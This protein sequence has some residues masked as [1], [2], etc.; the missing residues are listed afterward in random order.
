MRRAVFSLLFCVFALVFAGCGSSA[1]S[2]DALLSKTF[3][4]N[5]SVK[6]GRVNAQIDAN[7]QG[8]SGLNG[9]RL[10]LNGPF[11][12]AGKDKL[13]RFDFTL[14]ISAG[15]QAFSAGGVST[16][17][18]GWLRVNGQAYAVPDSVFKRFADSYLAA[19]RKSK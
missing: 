8:V 18:H 3:G 6:S 15:G 19:A 10:R 7:V 11:E 9:L 14:G 1:G 4:S 5:K 2:V 12:S 13:P 17:S 16:G